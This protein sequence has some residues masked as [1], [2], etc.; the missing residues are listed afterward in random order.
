MVSFPVRREKAFSDPLPD[1]RQRIAIQSRSEKQVSRLLARHGCRGV[2]DGRP[3]EG[4]KLRLVLGRDERQPDV[5]DGIGRLPLPPP[6]LG[7]RRPP[8][9]EG[10]SHLVEA[11]GLRLHR[12]WGLR[13]PAG[14]RLRAREACGLGRLQSTLEGLL[15]LLQVLLARLVLL[16]LVLLLELRR[17]GRDGRRSGLEAL[18]RLALAGEPGV[19][20][21]QRL[22][23][24]LRGAGGL[25]LHGVAGV[26]LLKR[27]L[28]VPGGLRRKGARLLAGLLLASSHSVEGAAILLLL[29]SW[30]L[31][32]GA[33]VGVRIGVHGE[34]CRGAQ[35]RLD[36]S[37]GQPD[38][39][40]S[41]ERG[42]SA[43]VGTKQITRNGRDA[44]KTEA[45]V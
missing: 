19:L 13:R 29:A 35:V 11:S 39:M 18:L 28:A 9:V 42:R 7:L 16:L 20:L 3:E 30:A 14:G 31:A 12:G 27:L 10:C 5:G 22:G 37:G 36:Y 4:F 6:A 1:M 8:G 33:Q 26:L 34:G 45:M 15:L 23:R 38:P 21:L 40:W 32:V 43:V 25:G 2:S 17:N 24:S 41:E 44:W